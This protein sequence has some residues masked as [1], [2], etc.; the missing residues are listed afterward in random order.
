MADPREIFKADPSRQETLK[1]LWPELYDALI[2]RAVDGE[3]LIPCSL[4]DCGVIFQPGTPRNKAVGRLYRNGTPACRHHI[5]LA[6]R[7]GGWPLKR[8]PDPP[9]GAAGIVWKED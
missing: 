6:D 9:S 3:P 1:I 2:P 4:G 8:L 5:H 7:P